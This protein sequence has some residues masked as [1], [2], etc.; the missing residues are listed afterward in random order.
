MLPATLENKI[1]H[2]LELVRRN[3]LLR[4]IKPLQM[5]DAGHAVD[6][7]HKKLLVLAG[8]NYLGLAFSPAVISAAQQACVQGASSTG[9]RLT[10]GGVPTLSILESELADFKKAQAALFFNTGYM[11]NV[12]VI[13]ALADKHDIIFSD[14]L[15]HASII[16]GA[17]LS[18]AK[19]IVYKHSD[20]NDL[21]QKLTAY[22]GFACNSF[23][24]TDGVFSM[25]G[26]IAKLP[27]LVD[28]AEAHAAT[29]VVDD[30]HAVG[31]L[32]TTGSGTA[33]HFGLQGRIPIQIGTLS[34]AL[35]GEGGYVAGDQILIDYLT[36]KARSFIFSTACS[37][38]NAAA[39]LVALRELRSTPSLL[40]RLRTNT[41]AIKQT[42]QQENIP[43][44]P[45]ETPIIPIMIGEA[46]TAVL[47]SEKLY[48]QGILLTAI[49]PPTVEVGKSRLRL[50]V[51]AS[52][53]LAE[54]VAAAR[55]IGR[56]Y[57]ELG[58]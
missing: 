6:E 41:S 21:Q 19:I 18:G 38:I 32:G 52:H 13:S 47:F 10:T 50:T 37:P 17:R 7:Q 58:I 12:G 46:K 48:A 4:G 49:R 36:N 44:L 42:L 25:D 30:A 53:N 45:S 35:S 51:S 28:I 5:L 43:L 16:D 29:L 57:R 11:T 55:T 24:I 31:V 26:D 56:I 3:D 22:A 34:K 8:N 15:N 20:M 1:N 33:E 14:E 54:L 27:E 40:E 23:V 39:V 2:N 9:A